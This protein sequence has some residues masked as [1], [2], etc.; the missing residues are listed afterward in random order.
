MKYLKYLLL[1]LILTGCAQS[2]Q[3]API[4]GD[5]RLD[6]VTKFCSIHDGLKEYNDI[7]EAHYYAICNDNTYIIMSYGKNTTFVLDLDSF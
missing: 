6:K 7:D 5:A 1:I 2:D 4:T 3:Y